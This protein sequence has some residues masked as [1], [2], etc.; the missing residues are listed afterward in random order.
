[1]AIV[2]ALAAISS[3]GC[4]TTCN[5]AGGFKHPDDEPKIYGGVQRDLDFV[6]QLSPD[7]PLMGNPSNAN[8]G[9][10]IIIPLLI[11]EGVLTCV[12][13]TVTLPITIYLQER[14][15]AARKRE[16]EGDNSANSSSSAVGAALPV[17]PSPM[18]H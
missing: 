7:K 8:K 3:T 13:D 15:V 17:S 11:A 18:Q 4:G 6:A 12:G 16:Q 2:A 9:V 14:R 10:L 1:M 5:L